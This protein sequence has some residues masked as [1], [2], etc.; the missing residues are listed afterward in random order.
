[1]AGGKIT[2]RQKEIANAFARIC[3][4]TGNKRLMFQKYIENIAG[5]PVSM[6]EIEI[7]IDE[8][9]EKLTNAYNKES[10]E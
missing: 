3:T 6:D 9:K 8:M 7:I 10:E 4:L 5:R 1:M 2:E